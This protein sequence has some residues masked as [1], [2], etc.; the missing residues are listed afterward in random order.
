[1][2]TSTA[3]ADMNASRSP[4]EEFD[5]PVSVDEEDFMDLED[6]TQIGRA[7]CRERV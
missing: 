3:P 7:S 4:G 2:T 1:M 6:A 5:Q